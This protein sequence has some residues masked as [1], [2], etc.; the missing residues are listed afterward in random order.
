L[1]IVGAASTEVL[2]RDA[3]A[4]G[5]VADGSRGADE[6]RVALRILAAGLAGFWSRSAC[7]V[8]RVRRELAELTGGALFGKGDVTAG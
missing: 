7:A 2:E 1:V 6:S 4:R 5:D 3:V 8:E